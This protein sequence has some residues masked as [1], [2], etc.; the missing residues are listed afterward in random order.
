MDVN[1]KIVICWLQKCKNCFTIDDIDYDNFH[2]AIDILALDLSNNEIL[3]IEVKFKARI[4]IEDSDKK[5]NGFQHIIKQLLS[6]ER[7]NKIKELWTN[8]HNFTIV[9]VLITTKHFF[10]VNKFDYWCKEFENKKIRVYFF[11]KILKELSE[12]AHS[13]NKANDEILQTLRIL[14]Q[15]K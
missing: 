15:I 4:T 12:K 8:N 10:T 5:Q 7:D 1:E 13:L 6:E 3:D 14:N 2:S 9:K 11:D